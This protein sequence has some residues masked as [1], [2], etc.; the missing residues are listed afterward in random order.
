M[1]LAFG[2]KRVGGRG[3]GRYLRRSVLCITPGGLPC[4]VLKI[5]SRR[6]SEVVPPT[7]ARGAGARKRGVFVCA[8]YAPEQP[9]RGWFAA[10]ARAM[11]V[12]DVWRRDRVHPGETPASYMMRGMLEFLTGQDPA[13]Q[14]LRQYYVFL[15]IPVRA[16][17][18]IYSIRVHEPQRDK[19][20]R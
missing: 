8:R 10:P 17:T 6:P 12:R 15:I 18:Q 9:H 16:G 3:G 20:R 1:R 19:W 13:A 11:W 5:S 14:L 4:P 7:A 2:F